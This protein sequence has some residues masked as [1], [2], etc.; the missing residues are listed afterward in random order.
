MGAVII[1][2]PLGENEKS[3]LSMAPLN[4]RPAFSSFDPALIFAPYLILYLVWAGF[5]SSV[6]SLIVIFQCLHGIAVLVAGWLAWKR[7]KAW[8]AFL[9][10][11]L[12]FFCLSALFFLPGAYLEYP[13][14]PWEHFRRIF[15]WQN[16]SEVR[17]N[18][19]WYKFAYFF[20]Y[21][22][23]N[24]LAVS[25]RRLAAD[26]LSAFWQLLLAWQFYRLSKQFAPSRALA[27]LQVIGVFALFGH[28]IFSFRYYALSSTPLAFI[29]YLGCLIVFLQLRAG[30]TR[31][32]LGT[33][34]QV[35]CYLLLIAAN[36]FQELLLLGVSALAI[37]I[38]SRGGFLKYRWRIGLCFVVC[39]VLSFVLMREP[40]VRELIQKGIL[41]A[42]AYDPFLGGWLSKW[43]VFRVWKPGGHYFQTLG[44]HGVLSIGL[45][46]FAYRRFPQI[47]ALTL[48]PFLLLFFPPF[49][50][51]LTLLTELPNSYRVLYAF[52]TSFILIA[53]LFSTLQRRVSVVPAFVATLGL[54]VLMGSF[55]ASP[56]RGRLAFQL[57]RTT[58]LEDL[59]VLDPLV[60][61]VDKNKL[62]LKPSCNVFSD[63]MTSFLLST[64]FGT[65]F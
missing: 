26:A 38:E 57:A 62:K 13:S 51:A 59:R 4:P 21:T 1:R 33:G 46:A 31:W 52:P 58:P 48:T 24:T 17:G 16:F 23:V 40:S 61:W 37:A 47:A 65:G 10:H 42:R 27:A 6:E 39:W 30:Q 2:M 43:G 14:D 56:W 12:F 25:D 54:V 15:A 19:L 49:V 9:P 8:R 55:S 44:I 53:V 64:H 41:S 11:C 3:I 5:G 32:S 34:V 18:P 28:G 50:I 20:N 36:H 45:A 63:N 60:H 7:R 29:A 22:W 35:A